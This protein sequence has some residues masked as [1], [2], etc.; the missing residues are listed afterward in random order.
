M[1]DVHTTFTSPWRERAPQS[2]ELND[3]DRFARVVTSADSVVLSADRLRSWPIFYRVTDDAVHIADDAFSLVPD[4]PRMVDADAG[5]T[6]EH[7]GFVLGQET[8]FPSVSQVRAGQEVRICRRTGAVTS[9]TPRA[10]MLTDSPAADEPTMTARF[11]SALRDSIDDLAKRA[12][13]RT[14]ALPMSAGWDSRLLASL[15][16]TSAIPRDQILAF[17]Y[18]LPS[19]AESVRSKQ[20]ADSLNIPWV[21]TEFTQPELRREWQRHGDE[22]FLRCSSRGTALPHIQDWYAIRSLT[23]RGILSSGSI[24]IPGHTVVSAARLTGLEHLIDRPASFTDLSAAILAHIAKV[25]CTLQGR[26]GAAA[27]ISTVRHAAADY[28]SAE[29]TR[30][31]AHLDAT[32]T[33]TRRQMMSLARRVW[34]EERQAKYILNSVRTY[35][36]FGLDWELPLHSQAAWDIYTAMPDSAIASRDWYEGLI[37][38]RFAEH[39]PAAVQPAAR[40]VPGP[41]A[42]PTATARVVASAKKAGLAVGLGVA[43]TRV[44]RL[45]HV[46]R[47]PLGFRAFHP[48][49]GF[50]PVAVGT[51]LGKNVL[52]LFA[53]LFLTDRWLPN[54]HL[55]NESRSTTTPGE[56]PR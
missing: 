9:T 17:T 6:F 38:R 22:S 28:A 2:F 14:L 21:K 46:R 55:F 16:T 47:H 24:V 29:F 41:S 31:G 39:H 40:R 20:I 25:H 45:R 43:D 23:T 5:R 30:H 8:L 34:H 35:E 11:D 4:R 42:R 33:V 3:G 18:G 12:G 54:T 1:R 37:R 19:D 26:P 27:R 53:R 51:L 48:S 56:D 15:L 50:T 13:S 52:G 10:L 32:I 36:H 49:A 7:T 44:R